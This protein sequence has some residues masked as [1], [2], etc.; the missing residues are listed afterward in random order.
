MKTYGDFI[1]IVFVKNVPLLWKDEV[2]SPW[3]PCF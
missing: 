3:D 2:A 1:L